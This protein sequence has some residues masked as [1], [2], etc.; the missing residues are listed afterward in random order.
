MENIIEALK[1]N[2][3]AFDLMETSEFTNEEMQTKA[4]DLDNKNAKFE[5]YKSGGWVNW[6][7][8]GFRRD[9]TYRLRPD[10]TEPEAGVEKWPVF[11]HQSD[12]R[13]KR[14][15][16]DMSDIGR[17]IDTACRFPNFIGYLYEDGTVSPHKRLYVESHTKSLIASVQIEDVTPDLKVLTPTHVLFRKDK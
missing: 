17:V 7:G 12:L 6:T 11:E 4:V 3:M 14:N 16:A 9:T 5:I 8:H 2:K 10:Y 15:L 13:F 1:N